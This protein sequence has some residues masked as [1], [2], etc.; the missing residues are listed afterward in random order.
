[1]SSIHKEHIRKYFGELN[2]L[3]VTGQISAFPKLTGFPQKHQTSAATNPR[4][5][6]FLNARNDDSLENNEHLL[7]SRTDRGTDPHH[8]CSVRSFLV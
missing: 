3:G 1:M 8:S 2:T 6:V 7:K 5:D 4:R